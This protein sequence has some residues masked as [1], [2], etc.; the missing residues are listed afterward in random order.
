MRLRDRWLAGM[1]TARDLSV[2]VGRECTHLD[3]GVYLCSVDSGHL[4]GA[5]FLF[6]HKT[7]IQWVTQRDVG[8]QVCAHIGEG[9]SRV[10]CPC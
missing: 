9:S 2:G 7:S 1:C 10:P 3:G 8:V 4:I 6:V 5:H